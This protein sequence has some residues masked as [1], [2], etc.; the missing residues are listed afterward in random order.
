MRIL[1]IVT[2]LSFMG[3]TL[4]AASTATDELADA[5]RSSALGAAQREA[6]DKKAPATWSTWI[7]SVLGSNSMPKPTSQPTSQSA[8]SKL[9]AKEPDARFIAARF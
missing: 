9:P 7:N 4:L 5:R 3:V 6:T 2:L 1:Y 8:G